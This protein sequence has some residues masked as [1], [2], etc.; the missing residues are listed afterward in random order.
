M[1]PQ[2]IQDANVRYNLATL[3][4]VANNQNEALANLYYAIQSVPAMRN[5]AKKDKDFENLSNLKLFR[6]L[7]GLKASD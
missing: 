6:N 5:D 3:Y 2:A 1:P 4:A 7:V